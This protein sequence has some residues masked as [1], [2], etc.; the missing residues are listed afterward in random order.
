M[1]GEFLLLMGTPEFERTTTTMSPLVGL[2]STENMYF[3]EQEEQ[4]NVMEWEVCAST[5]PKRLF[6]MFVIVFLNSNKYK[7]EF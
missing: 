6:H 7:F 2:R 4:S 1:E 5:S 3:G